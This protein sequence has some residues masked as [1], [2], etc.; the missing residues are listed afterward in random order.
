MDLTIFFEC[1]Y[2]LLLPWLDRDVW[3]NTLLF[4]ES[5]YL[6]PACVWRDQ[7]F[8]LRTNMAL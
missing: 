8:A 6:L 3:V 7:V 2:L 4:L 1:T 5:V